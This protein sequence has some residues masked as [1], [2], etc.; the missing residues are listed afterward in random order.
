M[1][2]GHVR[3]VCQTGSRRAPGLVGVHR[4]VGCLERRA[5]I[6][7]ASD[8]VNP[9][10]YFEYNR[11]AFPLQRIGGNAFGEKFSLRPS[12]VF[13]RMGQHDAELITAETPDNVG[14]TYVAGE[15]FR[16][17]QDGGIAGRVPSSVV[18]LLQPV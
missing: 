9:E 10:G 16:D 17:L 8:R 5:G 15:D 3:R 13:I 7:A 18:K 2:D 4:L 6:S 11:A 1:L 12:G 14:F